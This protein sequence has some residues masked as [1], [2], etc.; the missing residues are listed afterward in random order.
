MLCFLCLPQ[1]HRVLL[2]SQWTKILDIIQYCVYIGLLGDIKYMRLDGS[3]NVAERQE[4]VDHYNSSDECVSPSSV[5]VFFLGVFSLHKYTFL[6]FFFLSFPSEIASAIPDSPFGLVC[7]FQ[8]L[9]V[10]A[11]YKG[12]WSRHHTDGCRH[13]DPS[14][15]RLQPAE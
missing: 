9:P 10:F 7:M 1:G 13:R 12:R 4:L 6:V 11:Q 8:V 2:F 5:C 3:T 14:R 15:H